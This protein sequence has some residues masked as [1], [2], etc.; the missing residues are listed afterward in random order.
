MV[1]LPNIKYERIIK[2]LSRFELINE[3]TKGVSEEF[4]IS[5]KIL[6]LDLEVDEIIRAEKNILIL[7]LVSLITLT[8]S[9]VLVG[10]NPFIPLLLTASVPLA[11]A[12]LTSEYPK[13][14]AKR[15]VLDSLSTAP[16]VISILAASLKQNPNLEEAISF[17]TK[18]KEGLIVK[19]F[20]KA[21][22]KC[23]MGEA[24][25][26]EEQLPEIG[27]K[28]GKYLPGFKRSL[29]L[30]R[31]AL[32]EQRKEKRDRLL[33]KGI[34]R[35]L[36]SVS[37]EVEEF[38][39]KLSTPTMILFSF[40]TVVPLAF[41]SLFP[42]ITFIG[43]SLTSLQISMGL[44][45]TLIGTYFYSNNILQKRPIAFPPP[46]IPAK[47]K[48]ELLGRELNIRPIFYSIA[49]AF[50]ISVP[51]IFFLI[52]KLPLFAFTGV[53]YDLLEKINTLT[54]VWGGGIGFSIFYFTKYHEL[55][56][57]REQ[58]KRL[59]ET[60][61]DGLYQ[62]ANKIDLNKS[63]ES[64][65]KEI[66]E[67][68]ERTA[69]GELFKEISDKLRSGKSLEES[70]KASLSKMK[71]RTTRSL[72]NFFLK[73][74]QKGSK[75]ATQALFTITNYFE[76]VKETEEN[77]RNRLRKSLSMMEIS[78]VFLIPMVTGLT[79]TLQELLQSGIEK[80]KGEISTNNILSIDLLKFQGMDPSLLQLILGFYMLAI[81]Y[82]L[83]RYCVYIRNG[84]DKIKLGFEI[85]KK[86]PMALIVFS[87]T[88]FISRILLL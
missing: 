1:E 76:R 17:L 53:V 7:S 20:E 77:I 38:A 70:I 33:D 67:M 82:L 6:N 81:T 29:Y 3:K 83:I 26:L 13:I 14:K 40:G 44:V 60:I 46:E 4:K 86:M 48:V 75:S 34:E 57:A 56:K 71:S 50:L 8:I 55:S 15:K 21:L 31:S 51:G 41:I 78:A 9:C 24:E 42:I 28:W 43:Q 5:L 22:K 87:V 16:E 62:L 84:E 64:S 36:N 37:R 18:E 80:M 23:W 32:S 72:F 45:L 58:V 30:I 39:S 63:I 61:L 66:S 88:L 68:M 49:I 69:T 47:E 79:V 65:I 54:I 52:G 2:I 25:N 11:S 73:A 35:T 12:H 10:L 59:E 27:Y 74:Y 85:S 19:D